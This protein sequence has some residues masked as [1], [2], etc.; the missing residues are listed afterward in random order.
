MG[1]LWGLS[2]NAFLLALGFSDGSKLED[3]GYRF[4]ID[5]WRHFG[6]PFW[7]HFG[8]LLASPFSYIVDFWT[9]KL[10]SKWMSVLGLKYFLLAR[11]FWRFPNV[12][13][14]FSRIW[15]FFWGGLFGYVCRLPFLNTGVACAIQAL[16]FDILFLSVFRICFWGPE[17]CSKVDENRRL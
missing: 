14:L 16:H 12:F 15:W 7:L 11:F 1:V 4:L 5:F 10:G 6:L 17:W 13:A 8:G 9:S 2:G 3:F